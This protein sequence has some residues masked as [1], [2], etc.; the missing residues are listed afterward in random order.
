[1]CVARLMDATLIQGHGIRSCNTISIMTNL[2][3]RDCNHTF[4]KGQHDGIPV[5]SCVRE[6]TSRAN[7]PAAL[8]APS[9]PT[10]SS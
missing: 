2:K 6:S 3:P 10:K 8:L 1:M 7:V 4:V 5:T 9:L